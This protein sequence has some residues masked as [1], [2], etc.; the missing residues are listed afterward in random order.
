MSQVTSLSKL[1]QIYGS[2]ET[3]NVFAFMNLVQAAHACDIKRS[4]FSHV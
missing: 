3:A 2:L 1:L 4:T